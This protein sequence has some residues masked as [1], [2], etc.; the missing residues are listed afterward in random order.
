MAAAGGLLS[1]LNPRL[2]LFLA[3]AGGL[4]AAAIGAL[5]YSL[6]GR[7]ARSASQPPSPRG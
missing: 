7:R 2:V 5:V 3:G 6:H 4:V 1:S